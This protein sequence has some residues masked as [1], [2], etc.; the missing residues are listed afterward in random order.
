MNKTRVP[1]GGVYWYLDCDVTAMASIETG[2]E[3]CESRFKVG[4]YFTTRNSA[5]AMARKLR[6]VLKGADVIEMPSEEEVSQQATNIA[7]NRQDEYYDEEGNVIQCYG[8]CYDS[9]KDMYKWLK[10]KIVK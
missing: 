7:W 10:S 4:N 6:A 2:H 3:V 9:A 8:E 5:L 1:R